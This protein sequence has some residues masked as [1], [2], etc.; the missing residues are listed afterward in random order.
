MPNN[1]NP[2]PVKAKFKEDAPVSAN[3]L[4]RIVDALA[5]RIVGD[6]KS[7]KVSSFPGGQI[8]IEGVGQK[9]GVA[10]AE[11]V[12]PQKIW[13]GPYPDET[14]FPDPSPDSGLPVPIPPTAMIRQANGEFWIVNHN[15]TGWTCI[16]RLKR[17]ST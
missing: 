1:A 12:A 11:D 13:W 17:S 6:G 2:W 9:T 7:I 15:R 10:I 8:L 4:A 14:H 3:Q 5:R 16:N